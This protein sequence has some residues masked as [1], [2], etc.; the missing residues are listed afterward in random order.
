VAFDVYR[1]DGSHS[2]TLLDTLGQIGAWGSAIASVE[3]PASS[4]SVGYH[5]IWVS[6]DIDGSV[7]EISEDNNSSCDTEGMLVYCYA[8]GF[9]VEVGGI[10][11]TAVEMVLHDLD[12]DGQ[13]ELIYQFSPNTGVNSTVVLDASGQEWWSFERILSFPFLRIIAPAVA[14]VDLDGKPE[15]VVTVPDVAHAIPDSIY[16]LNSEET[17]G[18]ESRVWRRG[19]T[20]RLHSAPL[21]VDLN[22]MDGRPEVVVIDTT[23]PSDV[24]VSVWDFGDDPPDVSCSYPLDAS[25]FTDT[26]YPPAV[27]V[28]LGLHAPNLVWWDTTTEPA[29]LVCMVV[30]GESLWTYEAS[31]V[32]SGG[33]A[34]PGHVAAGDL[35]RDGDVEVVATLSGS[36]GRLYVLDSSDGTLHW[37][38]PDVPEDGYV[39]VGNLDSGDDLEIVVCGGSNDTS[40]VVVF[41]DNGS[42]LWSK[43]LTG[44]I[45]VEP[46]LGDFDGGSDVEIVVGIG[47]NDA[48]EEGPRLCILKIPASGDTLVFAV[49]PL[50]LYGDLVSAAMGDLDADGS[51]DIVFIT[52]DDRGANTSAWLHRLEYWGTSSDRFEWPMYRQNP[53]HT[54]LYQQPVSGSLTESATWSGNMLIRGDVTVTDSDSLWIAA[55]T[56]ITVAS[57]FDAEST[58]KDPGLCELTVE[59]RLHAAGGSV[60]PVTFFSEDGGA[61]DWFGVIL[62]SASVCT[63]GYV[64]MTDAKKSLWATNPTSMNVH[65]CTFE[66]HGDGKTAVRLEWC[67]SGVEFVDNTIEDCSTGVR[68]MHS[69][70]TISGNTVDISAMGGSVYGLRIS[71]DYGTSVLGNTVS[72]GTFTAPAY[73]I[74]ITNAESALQI[75]L[76]EVSIG[77]VNGAGIHLENVTST[78]THVDYNDVTGTYSRFGDSKGMYFENSSPIVRWNEIYNFSHSSFYISAGGSPDL[79][80]T[81][82]TDGNN[83]TDTTADYSIYATM[84]TALPW[85]VMAENNWWG[86][87]SPTGRRFYASNYT[88]DYQPY[89]DSNPNERT[90][91]LHDDEVVA[92][93]YFL[94]QNKPN[95]FNPVTTIEYGLAE[96]DRAL[97]QIYDVAGRLVRTLVD[98][99]LPAGSYTAVWDGTNERGKKV[100]TGVYF[101]RFETGTYTKNRKMVLLK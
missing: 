27:A 18:G 17:L 66:N 49:E 39:V 60:H 84:K 14:D 94:S 8:A 82:T 1:G 67:G 47:E 7:T 83:A 56:N 55:G 89:L 79:G 22:P 32:D 16:I 98:R 80:D 101:C 70:V 28:N 92:H 42:V 99:A 59:G 13:L 57:R 69:D 95:P 11:G 71:N 87:S 41:D 9:P 93:R 3:W 40:E 43:T 15:I 24:R 35:D 36:Q 53:Q 29:V 25:E 20:G 54:G 19:A 72:C 68:V 63:L 38:S 100:A 62:E 50:T 85:P 51:N 96:N 48:L 88:I 61:A 90:D 5:D 33:Q 91:R 58:G 86:T 2:A 78:S 37:S 64:E 23:G 6:A 34:S 44:D 10:P 65:D 45:A 76:N 52:G 77:N 75:S 4:D 21:L 12:G 31:L 46:L 26:M 74:H 81:A 97:I 30:D 73:G